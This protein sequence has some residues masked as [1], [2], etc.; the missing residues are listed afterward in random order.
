MLP[1]L[2]RTFALGG[3]G[4]VRSVGRGPAPALP[5]LAPRDA[6]GPITKPQQMGKSSLDRRAVLDWVSGA[7][8]TAS[9]AAIESHNK[10]ADD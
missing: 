7:K 6:T 2:C 1:E 4:L 3:S 10:E 5:L 9:P 8:E